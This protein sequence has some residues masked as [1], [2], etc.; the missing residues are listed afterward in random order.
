MLVVMSVSSALFGMI[1]LSLYAMFRT[2]SSLSDAVAATAQQQ[3]FAAQL[4]SDAHES[5][6]A[7][8]VAPEEPS[9]VAAVLRLELTDGHSIEYRLQEGQVE[10]QLR[11]GDS[12][13]SID[14]FRV[15][16]V[17]NEGWILDDNR[18]AALLTVYLHQQPGSETGVKPTRYPLKVTAALGITCLLP[19]ASREPTT[20]H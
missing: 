15:V 2:S 3:R 16:P 9:G 10:R 12:V 4:R 8:L 19:G 11:A 7:T 14:S 13:L 6:S 17:M 5:I 1:S 20:T 18:P